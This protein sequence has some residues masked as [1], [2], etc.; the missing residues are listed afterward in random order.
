MGEG[1]C[2]F[3]V[4]D[5]DGTMCAHMWFVIQDDWD[6]RDGLEV[7]SMHCSCRGPDSGS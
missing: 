3:D 7:N 4:I 1:H 5:S 6:W 2:H